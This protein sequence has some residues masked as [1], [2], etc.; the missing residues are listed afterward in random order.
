L[1]VLLV[2]LAGLPLD[3]SVNHFQHL[4]RFVLVEKGQKLVFHASQNGIE[5][6]DAPSQS[7]C[8]V[9]ISFWDFALQVK[10]CNMMLCLQVVGC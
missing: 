5:Q 6:V 4:D 2:E 8:D 3:V 9:L 1:D 10:H 7:G